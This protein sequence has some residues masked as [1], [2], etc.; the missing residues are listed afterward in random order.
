MKEIKTVAIIGMGALGI[1]YGDLL[2]K[3]CGSNNI[4]FLGNQKRIDKLNDEGIY[5]NHEACDFTMI[6]PRLN[7]F[8]AD[9]VIFA[10][11]ATALIES[12]ELAKHVIDE[13]SIIIS[14]LNGISSE[15]IIYEHLKN[16]NI[17]SCVAQG[18]DALKIDNQLS[19]QNFGVICLG[20]S[21]DEIHKK[22]A[23]KSL[24]NFFDKISMPY[25]LEDDIQHRLWGK[26]MLNVGVNQVVM[27]YEGTFETIQKEGEARNLMIKAKNEVILISEKKGGKKE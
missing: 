23:L 13:N 16:E 21:Q 24:L 4:K 14:V 20:I 9:L 25:V 2:V 5:C 11:K 27:L 7:N 18:M 1:M 8:K 26:W 19:Y 15:E 3:Q 12:I 22:E 6:D 17:I 10:V